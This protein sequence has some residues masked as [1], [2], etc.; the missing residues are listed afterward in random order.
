MPRPM[1]PGPVTNLEALVPTAREHAA[2]RLSKGDR[3]KIARTLN[4][5]TLD[6]RQARKIEAAIAIY[7]KQQHGH[8]DTTIGNTLA[9]V[10]ELERAITRAIDSGDPR[11][12]EAAAQL[13]RKATAQTSGWPAEVR[14][15]LICLGEYPRSDLVVSVLRSIEA[16]YSRRPRVN[17]RTEVLRIFCGHLGL[18]FAKM[19]KGSA[20]ADREFRR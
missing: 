2:Q 3:K 11:E 12:Q 18:A 17:P 9:A 20:S 10:H 1:S 13:M 4:R 19:A 8:R 14:W 16:D 6:E 15:Q 5:P 7:K